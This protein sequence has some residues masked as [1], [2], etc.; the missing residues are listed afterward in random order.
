VYQNKKDTMETAKKKKKEEEKDMKQWGANNLHLQ[1][2]P[3]HTPTN[4]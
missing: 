3:T 2:P 1:H 4:N